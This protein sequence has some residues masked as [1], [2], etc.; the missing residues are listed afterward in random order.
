MN[1]QICSKPAVIANLLLPDARHIP[2]LYAKLSY[3]SASALKLCAALQALFI[4]L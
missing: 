3:L 1:F 2:A 4:F